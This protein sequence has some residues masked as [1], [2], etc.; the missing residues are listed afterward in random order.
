MPKL[1]Q[2]FPR[3]DNMTQAHVV[4]AEHMA[5]VRRQPQHPRRSAYDVITDR[6]LDALA[7]G[8]VP[9]RKPWTLTTGLLPTSVAS[10]KP[11]QGI[12]RLLLGLTDYTDTRW[13]TYRKALE[14]DGHVRKGEKSMPIVFFK[15]QQIEEEDKTGKMVIKSIPIL[16]YDTVFNV[17]QCDGLTLPPL[18]DTPPPVESLPTA[19]AVV[20]N[21]PHRPRI[22][23]DG[24]NQAFYRPATDSVHMP[25]K[26]AFQQS[27]GYYSVLFHELGHSTGHADRLDR[28]LSESIAPFGSEDYSKEELVAEFT[29]AFLTNHVGIDNTTANSASYIA[30]W[31]KVIRSDKR[32]IVHAASKAQKAA[33]YIL[34]IEEGTC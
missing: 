10:N 12:N 24:G 6:I 3:R 15:P 26:A 27:S 2:I 8:V 33:N 11:Y 16:K 18:D 7:A 5:K 30:N 29:A 32:L 13:L 19:E 22:S 4:I 1:S 25:L 20:D 14:L 23:N 34:N 9:W 21:M 28:G 17:Q 31:G